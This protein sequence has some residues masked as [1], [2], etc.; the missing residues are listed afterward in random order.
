MPLGGPERETS[1]SR[2]LAVACQ[3]EGRTLG[4]GEGGRTTY[5]QWKPFLLP[6]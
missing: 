2:Q 1:W 5:I 6:L 3:L 4:L